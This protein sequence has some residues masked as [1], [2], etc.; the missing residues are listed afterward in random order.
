MIKYR[1]PRN[2]MP[3][4]S[5]K[6]SVELKYIAINALWISAQ[7]SGGK[8]YLLNLLERLIPIAADYQFRILCTREGAAALEHMNG[9]DETAFV[10]LPGIV[11]RPL[12]RVVIEQL[13][14][15]LWLIANRIDLLFAPRNVMPLLA[16]CP[17]VLTIHSMH[18]NYAHGDLPYWRKVYGE[19]VLRY[20]AQRAAKILAVSEYAA[21]TF[22]DMYAVD[23][24]RITVTPEG[25]NLDKMEVSA[26][27]E[28]N[29][30]GDFLLFVGTLFPHKN[31][32]FLLTV[33]SELMHLQ[34]KLSL[35]I[36]GRDIDHARRS[37]ELIADKL[38][39]GASL[40]ILG[41]VSDE[42]LMKLYQAAKI[43]VYPSLREGYGLPVLEAMAHGLPIV[44]S[45]RTAIPEVVGN[46]GVLLDPEDIGAWVRAISRILS[47]DAYR[48]QL[49]AQSTERARRFTWDRTAELTLKAITEAHK[50]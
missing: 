23:D 46:A 50:S 9:M 28:S 20:S 8:T 32:P 16:N 35:A 15:P 25:F 33:L 21:R 14:L 31:I 39:I 2:G 29:I 48:Q 22:R 34:H 6:R 37:L 44:A 38:S 3:S 13:F 41:E 49:S 17:V 24:R 5:P 10:I 7:P 40:H 45:S 30:K 4:I 47:D 19:M 12:V 11:S 1:N 27:Q 26:D 43:F 42:D 18:L 36:V